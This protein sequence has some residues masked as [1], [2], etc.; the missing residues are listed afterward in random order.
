VK[1]VRIELS[2]SI[3]APIERCFDLSRSIDLH[4]ASTAGTGEQAITGVVS[5]LIGL[6]QEVTWSGRHFGFVIRHTSRI[7]AYNFPRYFQDSMLRGAF[8]SYC[9]DHYF[10]TCNGSTLMKDV[11][12]F[13]APYGPLGRIVE[14]LAVERHMRRLLERRNLHIK[15]TAESE[16]YKKYL[17]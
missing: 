8:H 6:G 11:V 5:G 13:A 16:Q 4:V 9:H 17:A 7:T 14:R 3:A 2:T 1:L 12:R 10:E 15:D